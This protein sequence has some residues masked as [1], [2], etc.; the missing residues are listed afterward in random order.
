MTEGAHP[1]IEYLAG[2]IG[3]GAGPLEFVAR[4]TGTFAGTVL[5][6]VFLP[7][8]SKTEAAS[9]IVVAAIVGSFFVWPI[10]DALGWATVKE[11]MTVDEVLAVATFAAFT[12]WFLLG[13]LVR[14]LSRKSSGE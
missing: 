3:P 7:P 1:I 10:G 13:W 9:R 12:S 11:A 6:V 4:T 2:L 14:A 8:K 5:A